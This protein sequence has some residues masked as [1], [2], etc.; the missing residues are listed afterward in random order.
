MAPSEPELAGDDQNLAG[1]RSLGAN[2]RVYDD[3]VD[4]PSDYNGDDLDDEHSDGRW[5]HRHFEVG[6]FIKYVDLP[7]VRICMCV[8]VCV[9]ISSGLY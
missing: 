3:D 6:R 7:M 9:Y 2:K 8:Y 1:N 4:L 5:G